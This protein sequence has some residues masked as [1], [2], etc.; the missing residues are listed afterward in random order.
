MCHAFGLTYKQK[1]ASI[2]PYGIYTVPEISMAGLTEEQARAAGVDYE[3]GRCTSGQNARGQIIG[4]LDGMV[5][6]VFRAGDQVL[7]GVHVIGELAAEL[8]HIGMGCL[9]YGGTIDFFI[10]SVFNFPTLSDA[11]KYAAYDGLGRL[12]RRTDSAG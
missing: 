3:I 6:L 1:M 2:L 9:Y 10:Q 5:K 7:L 4:D 11:F 12:S 8:V